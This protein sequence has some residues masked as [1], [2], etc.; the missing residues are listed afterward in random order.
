MANI[1]ALF[2]TGRGSSHLHPTTAADSHLSVSLAFASSGCIG[3]LRTPLLWRPYSVR[4]LAF[5][6]LVAATRRRGGWS[7]FQ[8]GFRLD[9]RQSD[10]QY[11][12]RGEVVV[13]LDSGLQLLT[14]FLPLHYP[15][16]LLW[17]I[18]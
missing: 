1:T 16:T 2:L 14:T 18:L 12:E 3:G 6:S 17:S 7:A 11:Y 15:G 8:H 4:S 5:V 10:H 13:F 9:P